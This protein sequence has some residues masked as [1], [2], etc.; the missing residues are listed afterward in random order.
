MKLAPIINPEACRP[1]PKPVQVDLRKVFLVISCDWLVALVISLILLATGFHVTE[2]VIICTGG[3]A[4]GICLLIWEAFDR[5]D[6]RRL[7][8]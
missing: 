8:M 5:R 1:A 3:V 4:I 7:G 2:A 6:Y